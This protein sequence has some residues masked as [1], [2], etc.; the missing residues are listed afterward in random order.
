MLIID[1]GDGLPDYDIKPV[2][3]RVCFGRKWYINVVMLAQQARLLRSLILLEMSVASPS[4]AFLL[5]ESKSIEGHHTPT[6]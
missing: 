2:I 1:D 4:H 5:D 3:I 6:R